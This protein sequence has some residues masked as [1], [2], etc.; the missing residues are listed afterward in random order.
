MRNRSTPLLNLIIVSGGNFIQLVANI[1]LGFLLPVLLDNWNYGYYKLYT[2]YIGYCGLLHFGFVDGILLKYA[3]MGFEQLDKLQFRAYTKLFFLVESVCTIVTV[4][5]GIFLFRNEYRLIAVFVGMYIVLYTMT[6]YYQYISQATSRFKEFSFRKVM[7]SGAIILFMAVALLL[8]KSGIWNTVSYWQVMV[9]TQAIA[10]G[11]LGWYIWTY[12]DITFGEHVPYKM[13]I[14]EMKELCKKGVV[15]TV[16]YEV[17]QLI[18]QLDRQFVS[19]FFSIE[20]YAQYAFAYNILSCITAMV[21]AISTV[22]FPL[23]KKMKKDQALKT[24]PNV[25]LGMSLLVCLAL[26]G[27]PVVEMVI[28]VLLPQYAPSLVYLRIVFPAMALSCCITI[29]MFTYFKVLD[30][31]TEYLKYSLVALLVS[32]VLNGVAYVV[33]KTPELISVASVVST[34]IWY[35]LVA[36]K[37]AQKCQYHWGKNYVYLLMMAM[38]SYVIFSFVHNWILSICCYVTV[39]I[40]ITVIMFKH[41]IRSLWIC[42]KVNAI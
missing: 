32:F 24:F 37:L 41:Q 15:L 27:T 28:K 39:Y 18:L 31:I 42:R 2:L 13:I 23:L 7:N 10:F 9:F 3:G 4:A 22:M 38:V 36:S 29:V 17:A 25:N 16:A 33:W 14:P 30:S 19:M 12:R 26:T 11:L 20:T 35:A 1:L 6:L 5:L 21:T 8:K 40:L 34:A